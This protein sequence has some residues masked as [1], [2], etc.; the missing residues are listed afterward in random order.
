M[1]SIQD[2]DEIGVVVD[3]IDACRTRDL[4]GLLD[5]Y[6]DNAVVEC[7]E[8]GSFEGRSG[9]AQDWLPRLERASSDAFEIYALFLEHGGV[10]LDYRGYD[11][12]P[13]RTLFRFNDAGKIQ[14]TACD[15]IRAAA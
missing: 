1:P 3:W 11:G 12:K 6:D 7:C 9:M 5:L 8:G 15:P 4:E 2:F 10:S 14:V 13:M